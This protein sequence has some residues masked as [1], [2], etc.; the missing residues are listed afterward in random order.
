VEIRDAYQRG[1][2]HA[3]VVVAEGAKHNADAL[4]QYFMAHAAQLGFD[5]RV[6]KLG[7]VQR[8]GAPGVADRMLAT[9]LGAAAVEHL[10]AQAHG[11]V[12]GMIGGQVVGTPLAD[13]IGR[14]KPLDASL[15]KLAHALAR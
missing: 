13:V 1:K 5:M 9:R 6:C 11:V 10:E 12:V 3:L 14:I 2:T 7:H 4:A 8:G 15:L